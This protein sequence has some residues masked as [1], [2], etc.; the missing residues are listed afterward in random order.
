MKPDDVKTYKDLAKL[1][2]PRLR[3]L[4]TADTQ[5]E[6]VV[7]MEKPALIDALCEAYKLEK[8]VRQKA[9]ATAPF[10]AKVRKVRKQ[11]DELLASPPAQ[12][13]KK[14]LAR[15]RKQIKGL[16]RKMRKLVEAPAV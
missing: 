2:V 6:G 12:R 11:R 5:L 9:S 3:E 8:P 1:N 16:K 10:K 15:A 14:Q 4:A 13:D 7:A